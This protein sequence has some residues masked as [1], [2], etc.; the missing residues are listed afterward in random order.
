MRRFAIM[1][2]LAALAGC[3]RDRGSDLV[4]GV[5][6]TSAAASAP[7]SEPG[8]HEA[9]E[10]SSDPADVEVAA[11]LRAG[12]DADDTLS[13]TAKDIVIAASADRIVLRGAVMSQR[14]RETLTRK[15]RELSGSRKVDDKLAVQSTR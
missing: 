13:S 9:D 12:I 10:R 14:E 11:A 1:L 8:A 15:A 2:A 3:E 4:G 6:L 5:E 7:A